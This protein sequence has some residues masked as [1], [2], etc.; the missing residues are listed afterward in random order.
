MPQ[1]RVFKKFVAAYVTEKL[2]TSSKIGDIK[3]NL[4]FNSIFHKLSVENVSEVPLHHPR[5]KKSKRSP[6]EVDKELRIDIKRAA[7]QTGTNNQGVRRILIC[8]H[9][10]G[11]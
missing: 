9:N 5:N 3:I 1:K 4:P 7:Q 10:W 11:S 6:S 2:C 8:G